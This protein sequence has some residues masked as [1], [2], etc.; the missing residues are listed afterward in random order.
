MSKIVSGETVSK[1]TFYHIIWIRQ[2]L[3][4]NLLQ[5][6]HD[7]TDQHRNNTYIGSNSLFFIYSQRP[8]DML[9]HVHRSNYFHHYKFFTIL[10]FFFPSAFKSFA[11]SSFSFSF[12]LFSR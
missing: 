3:K 6:V 8:T 1:E 4:G 2:G 11:F 12:S 9:P 7:C 10:K 5:T